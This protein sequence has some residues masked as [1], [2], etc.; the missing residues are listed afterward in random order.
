MGHLFAINY[1]FSL[2]KDYV[3]LNKNNNNNNSE[4]VR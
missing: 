1:D 4:S 3:H 2:N